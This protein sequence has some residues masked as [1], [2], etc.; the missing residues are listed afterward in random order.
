M[1]GREGATML[2]DS[3]DLT[4]P[5]RLVTVELTHIGRNPSRAQVFV[6]EHE[7][8]AD[9]RHQGVIDLLEL[10]G[11][12]LPVRGQAD[13]TPTVIN[14]LTLIHVAVDNA[15]S[16]DSVAQEPLFEYRREVRVELA[17]GGKLVGE[18]LYTLPSQ[19]AR[20]ADYLNAPGRFF[21]LWTGDR[22]Y[23][24]NKAHVE[25]VV[26]TPLDLDA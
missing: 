16:E 6:A 24:V 7:G 11:D 21:S 10:G 1:G 17:G 18:L 20:V 15:R 9:S 19:H 26:E 2:D 3:P 4:V 14:R 23:L 22:L 5:K 13:E 12:F 8:Q 25:R